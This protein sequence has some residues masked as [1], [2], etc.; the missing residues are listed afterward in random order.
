M[1][2]Q[3]AV[4]PPNTVWSKKKGPGLKRRPKGLRPVPT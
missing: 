4:K 1:G 2:T 3:M